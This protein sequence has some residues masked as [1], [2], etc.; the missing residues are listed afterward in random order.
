MTGTRAQTIPRDRHM[1][2]VRGDIERNRPPAP[3]GSCLGRGALRRLGARRKAYPVGL[4]SPLTGEA[5]A[6]EGRGVL[7]MGALSR[8]G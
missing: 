7:T 6:S 2:R 3:V 4:E 5:F 8:P 1:I